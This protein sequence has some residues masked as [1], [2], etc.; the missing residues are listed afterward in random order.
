MKP[1]AC[2]NVNNVSENVDIP[3]D[4]LSSEVSRVNDERDT[5]VIALQHKKHE[6]EMFKQKPTDTTVRGIPG[7]PITK[8]PPLGASGN[9]EQRK[10]GLPLQIFPSQVFDTIYDL[11]GFSYSP[12]VFQMSLSWD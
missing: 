1:K 7:N 6:L 11:D 5:L 9:D 4:Y 2:R 12:A 10:Q 8:L 3:E